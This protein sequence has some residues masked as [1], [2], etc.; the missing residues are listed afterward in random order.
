MKRLLFLLAVTAAAIAVPSTALA[1]RGVALTKDQA[2]HAVVVATKS[3]VVRTV[4]APGRLGAVRVGHRVVYTAKRLSDGTFRARSIRT[5]GRVS[6]ATVRGVV[7]R[8]QRRL[9]RLLISAGGSVF[10]V[11][12]PSRGFASNRGPRSGDRVEVRVRL[13]RSGLLAGFVKTLGHA[14]TLELEGIFLGLNG[15]QLRLAVEHRG[16]VF[17]TVPAGLRL[18]D[19]R[20]GDEIELIVTVDVAGAFTLVSVQRDDEDDDDDEGIEDDNG[21]V[22]VEGHTTAFPTG[23]ITVQSEHGSPVTCA[24]PPGVDLSAF[25]VGDRVEMRCVLVHATLTLFRLKKEDDDDHG[26]DDGGHHGGG[27]ISGS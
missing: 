11:R 15:D 26:G 12:A 27:G 20:P 8:N 24:V 10:A 16:E 6:R 18:P 1:A 2:R 23:G 7:V 21:R 17:V 3:G 4:R 19:L 13:T 22:R 25:R 14:G 9:N 5:A